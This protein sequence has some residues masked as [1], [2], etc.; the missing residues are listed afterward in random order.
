MG[1]RMGYGMGYRMGYIRALMGYRMVCEVASPAHPKPDLPGI[2]WNLTG[3]RFS[4]LSELWWSEA[5]PQPTPAQPDPTR[6]D[7]TRR[8]PAPTRLARPSSHDSHYVGGP[9][10]KQPVGPARRR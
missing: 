3:Q 6:P 8:N 10:S 1:Y 5:R 7:P 4:S 9:L 2:V